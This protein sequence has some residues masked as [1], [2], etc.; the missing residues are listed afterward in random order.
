M[1]VQMMSVWTESINT[2]YNYPN[3]DIVNIYKDGVLSRFEVR[4]H[5]NYVVYDTTEN[6]TE[7][8][9]ETYE[10]VPVTYYSRVVGLPLTYNFANF[11]YVAVLESEVDPNYIFGGGTTTPPHEKA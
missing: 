1:G 3:I 7:L 5:A 2:N 8:D 10:E 11:P 4:P 9:P 6:F